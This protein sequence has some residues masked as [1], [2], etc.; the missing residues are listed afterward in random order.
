MAEKDSQRDTYDFKTEARLK[1]RT[2]WLEIDWERF[3][4]YEA[5]FTRIEK[6]G[7]K[8]ETTTR[9]IKEWD[10]FFWEEEKLTGVS[11]YSTGIGYTIK[12]SLADYCIQSSK[13]S[14]DIS[15][16]IYQHLLRAEWLSRERKLPSGN[17]HWYYV[18]YDYVL[19]DPYG[20][21]VF[22]LANGREILDERI[23]LGGIV[24]HFQNYFTFPMVDWRQNDSAFAMAETK[25][26]YVKF[27]KETEFGRLWWRAMEQGFVSCEPE[28]ETVVLL[29]N[30]R[31]Q[32]AALAK[33]AK[34]CLW[35]LVVLALIILV[36]GGR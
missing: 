20:F 14:S 8:R 2:Y 22:F 19:D 26:M 35:V 28:Q 29:R 9:L 18:G 13:K 17:V 36:R 11:D 25:E 27:Y 1:S 21:S 12:T 23:V 4:E 5:T 10:K 16:E 6:V 15:H 33:T 24:S 32:V 30:V 3:R 31:E 34:W 7:G